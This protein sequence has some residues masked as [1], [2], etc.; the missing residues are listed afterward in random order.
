M[1]EYVQDIFFMIITS[2]DCGVQKVIQLKN[3][4]IFNKKHDMYLWYICSTCAVP[5]HMVYKYE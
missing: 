1:I 2:S 4:H 5:V 3:V